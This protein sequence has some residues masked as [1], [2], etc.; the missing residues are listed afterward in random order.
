MSFVFISGIAV[1]LAMDCFAVTLGVAAGAKGLTM[2][3]ALRMAVFFGGF[4]FVMPVAGWFAGDRLLALISR[5]DHWVAFGL[6]AVVGGRMIRESFERGDEEKNGRPD[7]GRG[8]RL[9]VLALATSIDAMAVGLSLG[10]VGTSVLYPAAV[11]GATSFVLTVVGAKLGPAV[12][13]IAGRRAELVGGLILIG[14]GIKILIE[15]LAG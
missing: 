4:Q 9:L 13:R 2:K 14:I 10:V 7:R 1:A 11:I 8:A 6:L 12:G 15:H 5:F 3:Q